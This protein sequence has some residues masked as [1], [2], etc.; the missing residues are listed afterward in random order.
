MA[1]DNS[2][3]GWPPPSGD[4]EFQKNVWFHAWAAL[5]N[6]GPAADCTITVRSGRPASGLFSTRALSFLK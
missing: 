5:L 2:P 3:V 6:I 4:I 1:S